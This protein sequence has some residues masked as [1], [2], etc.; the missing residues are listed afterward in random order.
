MKKL[1]N[2]WKSLDKVILNIL[3]AN[4]SLTD[5]NELLFMNASFDN[6]ARGRCEVSLMRKKNINSDKIL[7]HSDRALM[8]LMIYSD[9]K[10]FEKLVRI[11]TIKNLRKKK[12]IVFLSEGLSVNNKGYLYINKN[13]DVKV[14]KINWQIPIF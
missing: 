9:D 5:K 11:L 13:T 3:S 4:Y 2:S 12:L 8:E 14:Q 6:L 1:N 7:V 10:F